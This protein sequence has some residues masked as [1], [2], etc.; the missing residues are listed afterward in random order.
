LKSAVALLNPSGR[1][2]GVRVYDWD[3]AKNRTNARDH[4]MD[5]DAVYDFDWGTADI[6]I[7]DRADYGELRE[8]ATGFI[9]DVLHVLVYT[10]RDDEIRV[11]S[12]RKANWQERRRYGHGTR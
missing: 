11:I 12:L 8:I 6:Q 7:D 10:A 2:W 9:G 4:G 5:F 3:E 1:G